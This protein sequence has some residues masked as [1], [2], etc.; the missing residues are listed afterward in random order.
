MPSALAER[1][2][3]ELFLSK[4]D[5]IRRMNAEALHRCV[6]QISSATD[7]QNI[8]SE[9]VDYIFTD[10]PFGHNLMYSELNFI[11]EAW[12]NVF[13]DN[14][15]EASE[16]SAQTKTVQDYTDLMTAAFIEYYS[17]AVG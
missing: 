2:I 13:T 4:L 16:N 5:D 3:I 1:N 14:K 11:H 9:S 6:N 15:E 12:L 7:L 8:N 10:P 17:L